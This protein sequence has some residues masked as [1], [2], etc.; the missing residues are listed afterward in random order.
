MSELSVRLTDLESAQTLLTEIGESIA[1]TKNVLT[2]VITDVKCGWVGE[3]CTQ[4]NEYITPVNTQAETLLT[5]IDACKTALK[6][7]IETYRQL[8]MENISK[9][10]TAIEEFADPFV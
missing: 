6:D 3:A 7:T 5:T 4:F 9:I 2:N 8:E 1:N 10:N